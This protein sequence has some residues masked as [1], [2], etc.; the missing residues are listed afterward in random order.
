MRLEHIDAGLV[1]FT[2]QWLLERISEVARNNDIEVNWYRHE[3]YP[4]ALIRFQADQ[5]RPTL[6]FKAVQFERDRS[7]STGVRARASRDWPRCP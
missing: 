3:G 6:Q 7:R 4:V 5:A 2:A 1:P